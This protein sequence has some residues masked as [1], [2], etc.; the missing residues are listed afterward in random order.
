M[1]TPEFSVPS[2]CACFDV[3]EVVAVVTQ[4]DRPKGRGQAMAFSPV[5]DEALRRGVPVLQP[6]K[7][8][9]PPFVEQLRPY[10]PDIV[11][12][13]AYGRI[14]PRDLLTLPAQGC[15]NVHASLLPRWRGAAPIQWSIEAGDAE[16][17]VCLMQMEEGL[18]TGG[19]IARRALPI[20]PA[21]TSQALHE[22]LSVLGGELVRVELPRYLKGEL[23]V[24]P[25]P[26]EGVTLAP[27]IEKEMGRL[28]FGQTAAALERRIRAFNPWPGT[29][30]SLGGT[31]FKVHAARVGLG[32]GA[33][34]ELLH[35]GPERLEVACG[36]GSLLLEVVQPE[37]KRRMTAQEFL[38]GK[39]LS[40]GSKPF[41]T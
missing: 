5:K 10:A 30:T 29:F 22:R 28:D 31:L 15:V 24:V 40:L 19:V 8:K 27:L 3:G 18:D 25:Q 2:L 39:K 4:P 7:L 41:G 35:A 38:V 21:D 6:E 26:S 32:R 9:T 36:E 23:A 37:G 33:P 12:V 16:T 14:L 34:G 11:V 13:T 20:G 1:G 17:G